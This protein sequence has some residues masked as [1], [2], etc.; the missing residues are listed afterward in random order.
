MVR[1]LS[2]L[3]LFFNCYHQCDVFLGDPNDGDIGVDGVYD[4]LCRTV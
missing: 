4:M 1:K 3:G 2:L